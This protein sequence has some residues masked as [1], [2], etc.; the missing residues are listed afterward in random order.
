MNT[1]TTTKIPNEGKTTFDRKDF[2]A[3]WM[4]TPISPPDSMDKR[5]KL[6]PGTCVK[7]ADDYCGR[8][9]SNGEEDSK[10]VVIGHGWD[11]TDEERFV[12]RGTRAEFLSVW[13]ID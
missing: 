8:V 7:T 6:A 12:W 5:F 3:Q 10:A 4:E 13:Q 1:T 11:D 2:K 9:Q